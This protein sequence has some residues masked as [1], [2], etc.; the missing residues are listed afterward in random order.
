MTLMLSKIL[1]LQ[2]CNISTKKRDDGER[3]CQKV[4]SVIDDLK[5]ARKMLVK[6][7]QRYFR[8]L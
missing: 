5:A 4:T 6:L 8:K 7:T 1:Y 3:V 2:H